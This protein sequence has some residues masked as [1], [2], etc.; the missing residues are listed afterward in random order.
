MEL[1]KYKAKEMLQCVGCLCHGRWIKHSLYV[2]QAAGMLASKMNGLISV[3]AVIA[4]GY[5]HD[6][7][8]MFG[9]MKINHALQGYYFLK[10]QGYD[11][12]AKVCL[13]HSFPVK[14]VDTVT[15]VWDCSEKDYA[16]LKEYISSCEYDYYDKVIQLC[17]NI[18]TADGIVP[19]EVRMVDIVMRYGFDNQ[20][21]INR[22]KKCFDLKKEIEEIMGECMENVLGLRTIIRK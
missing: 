7:G 15:G 21:T 19:I 20:N 6:I 10:G 3:D 18:A 17:D 11:A 5:V 12:A 14:D 13:T 22:W 4:M 2:G 16:F 1:D 8:R 9:N